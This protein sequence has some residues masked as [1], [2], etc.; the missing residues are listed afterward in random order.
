M[1][2]GAGLPFV[3]VEEVSV[4]LASERVASFVATLE[5]PFDAFLGVELSSIVLVVEGREDLTSA[6]RSS[7]IY[8]V[9]LAPN[10]LKT[11]RVD[12]NSSPMACSGVQGST[13][14]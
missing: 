9:S 4:K 6:Q 7:Q 11:L 1:A 13:R 12:R 14:A 2:A 5:S 3:F 10:S 8:K